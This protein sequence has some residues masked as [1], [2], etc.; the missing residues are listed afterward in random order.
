MQP[1]KLMFI[2]LKTS[3]DWTGTSTSSCTSNLLEFQIILFFFF[4]FGS[5]FF[6]YW[7][8]FVCLHPPLRLLIPNFW[9]E[10]IDHL[11]W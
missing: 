7:N 8:S 2:F 9:L 10:E 3:Y 4:F 11:Q 6:L 5:H 1:M